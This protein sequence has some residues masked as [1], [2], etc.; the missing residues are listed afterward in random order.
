MQVAINVT[1]WIPPALMAPLRAILRRGIYYSGD[2]PDWESASREAGGY[3]AEIILEKVKQATLQVASGKA[4]FERDSVLFDKVQHSFPLLSGLLRAAAEDHGE[5]SV[6]DFG[7]SLGSSYFQCRDFLSVLAKV[8]W[9]VIEQPHFVRCGREYIEDAQLK[10]YFDIE[11]SVRHVAPN[12]ALCASVLQYLPEPYA[13]LER[14]AKTPARYL[15]I[16]RTPFSDSP[17]D[18]ITIQHVP[19]S[20]YSASYPCRIFSRRSFIERLS[21][22]FDVVADFESPDGNAVGGGVRFVFGGMIFRRK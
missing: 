8:Q 1:Q 14:L 10:F 3:D 7:G 4:V 21:G 9:N 17:R 5:L 2:H 11:E 19:P 15:I 22:Q 6:L 13:V 18:V 20:I 12:V 16:D